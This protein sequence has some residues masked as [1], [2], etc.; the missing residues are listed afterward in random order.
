MAAQ[1]GT[2]DLPGL[3]LNVVATP[4]GLWTCTLIVL[5]AHCPNRFGLASQIPNIQAPVR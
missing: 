2:D 4:R 3:L 5:Y 1:M